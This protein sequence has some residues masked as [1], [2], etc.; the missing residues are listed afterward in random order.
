VKRPG[1]REAVDWLATNDDCYWL[2]D[3]WERPM[4]SVSALLVADLWDVK[5]DKLIADLRRALKRAYP[6]HEALREK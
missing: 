3:E 1:Y 2:G 4:L 5:H 6:D